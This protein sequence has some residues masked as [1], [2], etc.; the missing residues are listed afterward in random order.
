[1][2]ECFISLVGHRDVPCAYISAALWAQRPHDHWYPP[3]ADGPGYYSIVDD[4]STPSRYDGSLPSVR[5]ERVD[6]CPSCGQALEVK[7]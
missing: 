7:G 3:G 6:R 5:F 4:W 2:H 1:M